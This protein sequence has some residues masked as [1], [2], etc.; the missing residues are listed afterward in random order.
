[1]TKEAPEGDEASGDQRTPLPRWKKAAFGAV[2]VVLL[3]GLLELTLLVA[4][5]QPATDDADPFVGF[6]SNVPHFEVES[7]NVRRPASRETVMNEFAFP[8]TK[9][10]NTSRIFCV[11]GS[12][13]YGRPFWDDTSFA[14]Y[15]RELLP[16]ASSADRGWVD[17]LTFDNAPKELR[18]GVERLP[19]GGNH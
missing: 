2:T 12:T 3:L 8:E 5:V 11:G 15:L 17:K 18:D 4:G 13:T 1:M 16:A 10:P 14:G 9:P 7:G 19:V 6:S